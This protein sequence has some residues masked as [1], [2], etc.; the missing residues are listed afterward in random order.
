MTAHTWTGV[1]RRARYL[2]TTAEMAIGVVVAFGFGYAVQ[3]HERLALLGGMALG[4]L[5]VV[6]RPN[7]GAAALGASIPLV[8][9]L[10]GSWTGV[11][12]SLSDILLVL[13]LAQAVAAMV[14]SRNPAVIR[15]LRPVAFPVLQ[16][17]AFMAV[18]LAA[19]LG[20]HAAVQS[21]QRLELVA[22][23]LL[24]GSYLAFRGS[25]LWLLRVYVLCTTA[26]AVLWPFDQLHINKNPAGQLLANAILVVV[27][28]PALSRLRIC[29]PVL[30]FGLL[31]TGSRGAI[32]ACGV[33][34][35][36]LLVVHGVRAPKRTI[37][38]MLVLAALV[39][40]AFKF[41]THDVQS[42][43]TTFTSQGDT[44]AAFTVRVR[45]DYSHDALRITRAHPWF[46]VGVGSYFNGVEEFGLISTTDPHEVVLLQAA[47]GGWG[48]AVSFVV[49]ILGSIFALLRLRAPD[50]APAAAAV[51][52][53]TVAHGLVDVYWVRSTP[54][55]GWLMVGMAC[56]VAYRRRASAEP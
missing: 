54:L 36:V 5:V 32:V 50:I 47:E 51:V 56:A 53:A 3:S 43:V 22:F 10:A 29:V 18:L 13:L 16:Y 4:A 30:V 6:T 55:L 42:R 7:L 1:P 27:G 25:H 48:F 8:E 26:I 39:G 37:A 28:M 38:Q 20:P 11:Q 14:V 9:N 35:A 24:V 41:S 21:V 12:V 19:H 31:A 46:G 49:L 23:P 34:L 15:A 17:C 45:E 44:G 40:V 33:G 52:L 2:R